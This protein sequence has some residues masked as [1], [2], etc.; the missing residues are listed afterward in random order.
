MRSTWVCLLAALT[1]CVEH[2][3]GSPNDLTGYAAIEEDIPDPAGGH[4]TVV[5]LRGP[6]GFNFWGSSLTAWARVRRDSATAPRVGELQINAEF[7]GGDPRA[8]GFT[9]DANHF[10]AIYLEGGPGQRVPDVYVGT[11]Q[12][13]IHVADLGNGWQ[14][15]MAFE[16]SFIRKSGQTGPDTLAMRGVLSSDLTFYED[17]EEFIALG[18]GIWI[19]PFDPYWTWAY[20]DDSY[21]PTIDDAAD[22]YE[23][24][25][26][27]WDSGVDPG[28]TG[29]DYGGDPGGDPG[30]DAG[31]GE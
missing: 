25:L 7:T 21:D 1:S 8:P 6:A 16:L 31:G 23:D 12:V 26:D 11:G 10:E 3:H 24:F 13:R 20:P 4:P 18:A 14:L 29:G 27:G 19:E 15:R 30:G 22:G 28:S 5:Q 2:V 9:V 17:D